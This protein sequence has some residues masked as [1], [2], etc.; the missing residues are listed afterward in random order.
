[1]GCSASVPSSLPVLQHSVA[2]PLQ[3]H[4]LAVRCA[5][6]GAGLTDVVCSLFPV[7]QCP[8]TPIIVLPALTWVVEL[9]GPVLAAVD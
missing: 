4:A 7:W 9:C 5:L 3:C 6:S 2:S 8:A 1:M